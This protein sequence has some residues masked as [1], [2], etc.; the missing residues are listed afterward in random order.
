MELLFNNELLF[1]RGQFLGIESIVKDGKPITIIKMGELNNR[2][3]SKTYQPNEEELRQ[4][5][6]VFS[7]LA[8]N[9]KCLL[10]LGQ[11]FQDTE[12]MHAIE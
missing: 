6:S 3:E 8:N 7:H 1:Q 10:E 11:P 4:L 2:K 5:A 9:P 12:P